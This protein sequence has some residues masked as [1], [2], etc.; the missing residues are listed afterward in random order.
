MRKLVIGSLIAFVGGLFAAQTAW[1]QSSLT[2]ISNLGQ[3]FDGSA[4]AG[5]DSWL[6]EEFRTGNNPGGYAF[7]SVQLSMAT[8]S[9][10]P[11]EFIVMMYAAG[12]SPF[13]DFP[14]TSV[15]TLNGPSDPFTAGTYAYTASGIVLSPSTDYFIVLTAATPMATG[16]FEWDIANSTPPN[17]SGEWS[18]SDYL[19]ESNDGSFGNYNAI[20]E[21]PEF[22]ITATAVPEPNDLFLLSLSGALFLACY[23]RQGIRRLK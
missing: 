20:F 23:R 15:G 16:A 14:G 9:G 21:A 22:A 18:G 11:S 8:A 1:S 17:S 5:S 13:A 10:E 2:Y 6:A 4:V 7:D 12:H 19:L 3:P